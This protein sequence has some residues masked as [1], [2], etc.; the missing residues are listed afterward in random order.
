MDP[1][2]VVTKIE[3]LG[4]ERVA[5]LMVDWQMQEFVDFVR[6]KEVDGRK[7]VVSTLC[8]IPSYIKYCKSR[9]VSGTK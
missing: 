4:V 7:L 1:D 6:E 5:E 9:V 3:D 8:F 2:K